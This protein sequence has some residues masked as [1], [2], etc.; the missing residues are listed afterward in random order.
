MTPITRVLILGGGFGGIYAA[1]RLE[2]ALSKGANIEVTLVAQDNFFLFTPLLHEVAGGLDPSA[3]VSPIRMILRKTAIFEAE[4]AGIDLEARSVTLGGRPDGR[5]WNLEYEHLLIAIG[6]ETNFFGIPGLAERSAPMKTLTDA[7]MLRNRVIAMLEA[8]AT[9]SDPEERVAL[10]TLVVAGGGFSGVETV[11]AMNDF[12]RDALPFYPAL[13]DA[14][15]RVVLVHPGEFILPEL[16]EKLGCY[17]QKKMTERGIEVLVQR[18]V[19]DFEVGK[20][21]LDDGTVLP[22]RTLIWTAGLTP[23]PVLGALPCQKEKQRLIV[24]GNFAIPGQKDVW[25]VGD[26]AWCIDPETGQPFPPTAQHAMRQGTWVADNIL[27]TIDGKTPRPFHYKSQGQLAVIG[28]RT[29][30]ANIYGFLFSGVIAWVMWRT[31]Y[32][33]KL[34]GLE[35]KIRVATEWTLNLFFPKSLVQGFTLRGIQTLS[36]QVRAITEDLVIQRNESEREPK[37]AEKPFPGGSPNG[38]QRSRPV[39]PSSRE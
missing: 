34:P 3:I 24:D 31:V 38:Q 18:R 17:S 2:R 15:L 33:M 8:A 37:P 27:A 21:T 25:A 6:S 13:H 5:T 7:I 35:K 32:L 22:S 10:L 39:A 12:V 29:G 1:M 11:G 4:V 20:V 16:G 19:A 26:C 9:S 14:K 23:S 28:K 36:S 30:V